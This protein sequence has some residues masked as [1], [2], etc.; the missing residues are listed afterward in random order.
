MGTD[1]EILGDNHRMAAAPELTSKENMHQKA[2]MNQMRRNA[3][4]GGYESTILDAQ[5]GKGNE[6]KNKTPCSASKRKTN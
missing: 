1:Q 3:I 4:E 5:K 6:G 2:L